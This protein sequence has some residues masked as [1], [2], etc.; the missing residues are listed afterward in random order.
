MLRWWLS[1]RTHDNIFF[2]AVTKCGAAL[3]VQ[4]LRHR[5]PVKP[6]AAG[7]GGQHRRLVNKW[8]NK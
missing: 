7:G 4:K 1:E 6:L 5:W 8:Q 2:L 3:N